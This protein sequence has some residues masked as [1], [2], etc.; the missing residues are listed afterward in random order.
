MSEHF[1][2]FSVRCSLLLHVRCLTC[3]FG[4]PLQKDQQDGDGGNARAYEV[5]KLKTVEKVQTKGKEQGSEQRPQAEQPVNSVQVLAERLLEHQGCNGIQT[6]VNE[7]ER[8]TYHHLAE[9]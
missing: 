8:Q 9:Q 6:D 7:T 1:P 4:E 2:Q 5:G 3:R